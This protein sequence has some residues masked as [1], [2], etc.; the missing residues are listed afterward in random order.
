[1][2]V[3]YLNDLERQAA[4]A[5][6]RKQMLQSKPKDCMRCEVSFGSAA[7]IRF[8]PCCATVSCPSCVSRRV[9]EVASRQ[10]VS[11]CSHCWRNSSRI[12]HPPDA[13]TGPSVLTTRKWW[14]M[15]D[16]QLPDFSNTDA[17]TASVSAGSANT[18]QIGSG[19][20]S[21]EVPG[22]SMTP[23][24]A[25]LMDDIESGVTSADDKGEVDGLH[26]I[27][28]SAE[29]GS[30]ND[31]ADP[32]SPR[33]KK[34][35]L[36]QSLT[37][38]LNAKKVVEPPTSTPASEVEAKNE[39][40]PKS[41]PQVKKPTPE[42]IRMA[43][44]KRCGELID[45][46]IEAIETHEYE[47]AAA[48]TQQSPR[49]RKGS[50]IGTISNALRSASLAFR[51]DTNSESPTVKDRPKLVGGITRRPDLEKRSE[52]RIIYRT[53]RLGNKSYKLRDVCALQDAFMDPDGT[54][55]CYEVSVRHCDARGSSDCVTSD[56]M[57]LMYVARPS[58]SNKSMANITIVSQVDSRA[59]DANWWPFAMINKDRGKLVAAKKEDLIRE[60]R[61]CGNLQNILPVNVSLGGADA[62]TAVGLD[63]FELL[64]VLGRGG[65]GKVMQVKHRPTGMIYAMKSLKK[66]ELRRR[67]QI[68]RT[69]TERTILAAVSHPFIVRLHFAFQS[70]AKLYMVMDFV[71]GGDF[72]T[73]MRKFRKL[74]EEWVRLYIA[75][76][77][78]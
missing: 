62:T 34:N 37:R 69:Q 26:T 61:A 70:P 24:L 22:Q 30:D 25:G 48:A 38:H 19:N 17:T 7:D 5:H 76:V 67:K 60:L 8:C 39:E 63:D 2:S 23:L 46:S 75:E 15:D 3:A 31:D 51:G 71:Q 12:R 21:I 6:L 52:T 77:S 1:M 72:F 55:Y 57:L 27:D 42:S 43:R 16:L 40:I 14:K 29:E 68:E 20:N 36:R 4:L 44:C 32:V 10:V 64:A 18:S 47:C 45:R 13:L 56:V 59:K 33:T 78:F 9:F 49:E 50:I 11:L 73:L 41:G 74:P 65:F 53:G 54:Y 66:T 58:R 28:E 35:V